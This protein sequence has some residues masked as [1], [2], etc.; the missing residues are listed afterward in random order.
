[1]FGLNKTKI[2]TD[3]EKIEDIL[4][5]GTEDIFVKEHLK[6][7]LL[8]GE[9]L[10]VKFGIDPTSPNIHLGRTVPLRKVKAFQDLGHQ[11]VLIIGDFTAKIADP[12]DKL[13]KRPMLSDEQI[14]INLKDYLMQIE[15]IIDL[16]KTE[17]HYNSEWFSSM[18][19]FQIGE[20]LENFTFQ[21]MARRRN[22]SERLEKGE[23][24]FVVELMYP[25]MQGYDSFQI[26]ADVE[27]GGFDQLFNLKAGRTIQKRNGQKEQDIMTVSMLLGTDGRKMSSS[28]GNVISLLDTKEDMYGKIMSVKDDLIYNYFVLCTD[29]SKKEIEG[30]SSELEKKENYKE[31]KMRLAREIITLY[32]GQKEAEEAEKNWDKT[33]SEG[34]VPNDI[35]TLTTTNDVLMVDI[36]LAEKIVESKTDWRRLVADGAVTNMKS[37]Q[38]ISDS[39]TKALAGTYKIGKRRFVKIVN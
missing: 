5:R 18:N 12:S 28:W 38:K 9:Q 27:I 16:S 33:F 8:S 21:Q 30:I 20:L 17:I 32:H 26:K 23:D 37:G 31:M 7:A 14:K 15:K 13:E 22:F 36:L 1:M 2:N 3:P 24:I 35:L 4:I 34:G 19:L 39:N 10:R 11:I 6:E 25:A 29:L